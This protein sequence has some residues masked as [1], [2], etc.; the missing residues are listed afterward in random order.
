MRRSKQVRFFGGSMA[1]A[2]SLAGSFALPG[3]PRD[4]SSELQIDLSERVMRVVEGGEEVRR[5][6][7]AVGSR[8]HPTP[9]GTFR[10]GRIVW[11]P[12]WVPPDS[13]WARDE[14]PRPPGDP[15]N[16]M[17][18]V[19]IYFREPAYYIHGTNAP[20]S[21]GQAASH[22]CIRMRERDAVKLGRW[23]EAK[24]GSV[25]LVIKG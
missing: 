14:K 18:G 23:I 20:G 17:R 13:D 1:L 22:G 8:K 12:G 16:P 19:K 21:I 9:R 7:V 15:K 24:G 5:Y 6:E 2:F 25:R 3:V 11:N 4:R 10:T